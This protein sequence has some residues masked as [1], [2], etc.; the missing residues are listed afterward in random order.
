MNPR[1]PS[2]Y[3]EAV[4]CSSTFLS[5][6]TARTSLTT[7]VQELCAGGI[8]A[9]MG[10]K[11]GDRYRFLLASPLPFS[12]AQCCTELLLTASCTPYMK[13]DRNFKHFF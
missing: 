7:T 5:N 13:Q 10:K 12:C 3:S 4:L 2:R 6:L 9:P 1:L 8:F 11:R